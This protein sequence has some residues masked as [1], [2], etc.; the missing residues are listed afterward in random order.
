MKAGCLT[1]GDRFSMCNLPR[2]AIFISQA[3]GLAFSELVEAEG[4]VMWRKNLY[5]QRPGCLWTGVFR[6]MP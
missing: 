4:R 6:F 3:S 5:E 1:L 2:R